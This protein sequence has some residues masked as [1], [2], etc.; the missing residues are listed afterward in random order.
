MLEHV[1]ALDLPVP[2]NVI[3]DMI[4]LQESATTEKKNLEKRLREAGDTPLLNSASSDLEVSQ[5]KAEIEV[6]AFDNLG[7]NNYEGF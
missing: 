2:Q 5:L 1:I 4:F 7:Y 3:N 6:S